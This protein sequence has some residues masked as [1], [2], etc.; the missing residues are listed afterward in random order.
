MRTHWLNPYR[1]MRGGKRKSKPMKGL[2]KIAEPREVLQ[3][4]SV[5]DSPRGNFLVQC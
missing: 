4:S 2:E 1:V 5:S 3:A